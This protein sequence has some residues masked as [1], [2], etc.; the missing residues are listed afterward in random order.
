MTLRNQKGFNIIGSLVAIS[1]VAISAAAVAGYLAYQQKQLREV[2]LANFISDYTEQ[3]E[4]IVSTPSTCGK[5]L[6]SNWNP[7]TQ[8]QVTLSTSLLNDYF[9][10]SIVSVKEAKIS[11]TGDVMALTDKTASSGVYS[12]FNSFF[13]KLTI[14]LEFKQ[15]SGYN[16][17]LKQIEIPLRVYREGLD[18]TSTKNVKCSSARSE[19]SIYV[20]QICN[21]YG[22][23]MSNGVQCDFPK[24]QGTSHSNTANTAMS[25][26]DIQNAPSN[27]VKRVALPEVICYLDTLITM[28]EV[29]P[30]VPAAMARNYTRFCRRPGG[31]TLDKVSAD[32]R[33]NPQLYPNLQK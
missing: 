24:V 18:V 6:P 3:V 20:S 21:L 15:G 2:W 17:L 31:P 33:S 27:R 4:D 23:L 11:V 13:G 1:I 28:T 19:S 12:L 9:D 10:D 16:H 26:V 29:S 14:L 7:L 30:L 32:L 25:V 5:V 22:G 8:P